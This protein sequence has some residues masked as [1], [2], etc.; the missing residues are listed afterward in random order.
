MSLASR[1]FRLK[2]AILAVTGLAGGALALA[3]GLR[4]PWTDGI[5]PL[6]ILATLGPC[7]VFYERRHADAFVGTL[8][9][10]IQLLLFTACFT[11]LMYSVAALGAPL[12][13]DA[14]IRIDSALGIHVPDVVAWAKQR[15]AL[16][17]IITLAYDSVLPQTLIVVLLLGFSGDKEPLEQFVLRFMVAL[18]ITAAIFSVAPAAGPFTAYGTE[19][20]PTQA[21]YLAQFEQLRDGSM[22]AVSLAD[23]EGLVTFPSFHTAWAVLLA[24]AVWHRKRLFVLFA[25]INAL[26]IVGTL[27]TGWHYFIDVLAG[28]VVAG[29]TIAATNRLRPWLHEGSRVES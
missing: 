6:A 21:S 13:D 7:A 22:T 28:A 26:V 8:L 25:T 24:V 20:N 2:L 11:V 10:V 16:D 5:A 18:L 19:M 3:A 9:A 17:L 1:D 12:C 23:T 27:T 15:P 29:V 4:F 14:L